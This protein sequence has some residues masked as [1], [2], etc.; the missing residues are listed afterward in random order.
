MEEDLLPNRNSVEDSLEEE[1]R[2]AYVGITRARRELYFS[3][4]S[5]RKRFGEI[6][7]CSP[8]RFLEELPQDKLFWEGKDEADPE[9]RKER[10][11]SHLAHMRS[12]LS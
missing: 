8:S 5:Y 9:E 6:M 10:G 2:L 4:A 3:L 11:K 7:E 12:M 1:R